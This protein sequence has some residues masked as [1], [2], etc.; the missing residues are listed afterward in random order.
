MERKKSLFGVL[1]TL[2][3]IIAILHPILHL[4]VL[5]TGLT[6][7]YESG[8]SG[9]SIGKLK[10]GEEI[11]TSKSKISPISIILIGIEW[12]ILIFALVF[13]VLKTKLG[14][15]K[16]VSKTSEIIKKYKGEAGKTDLDILL[17]V[18]N[19]RKSLRLSTIAKTFKIEEKIAH[20]WMNLLEENNLA[21]IQES[22]LGEPELISK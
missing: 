4:T 22:K 6:G 3:L 17:K 5:G 9:F 1:V 2:I 7:F 14:K 19:E 16:E 10:L 13:S 15:K 20:E 8:I 12:S 18:L 11:Q 21:T